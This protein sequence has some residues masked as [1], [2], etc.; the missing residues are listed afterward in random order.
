MRSSKVFNS[1]DDENASF[2]GDMVGKLREQMQKGYLKLAILLALTK[3]SI[4]GYEMIKRITERTLG[5]ITPTPGALYPALKDL[6]S[7][8]LIKGEWI[9]EKRKKVYHI[10]SEGKEAFKKVVEKH[11]DI[12]SSVRRLFLEGIRELEII[13]ADLSKILE[14][15]I[16][17]P[18]LRTLLLKE[19]ASLQE[20]LESLEA[21][22]QSFQQRLVLLNNIIKE[23]VL[24]QKQIETD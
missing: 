13:N 3:S 6:E 16:M 17:E 14:P 22:R 5:I 10:T 15:P 2:V 21:L 19:D 7:T 24:R 4:H 23:I 9:S 18:T 8:D 11:F 20:L 1:K 12:A